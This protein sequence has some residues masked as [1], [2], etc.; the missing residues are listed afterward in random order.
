[1]RP[2][3]N[4]NVERFNRTLA[5]MLTVYCEKGQNRW[6]EFLP[7]VLMAYRSSKHSST[8][9]LPNMM[10]LGRNITSPF[11]DVIRRPPS[12]GDV[13]IADYISDLHAKLHSV[14]EIARKNLKT[15]AE[16][17]K[18]NYDLKAI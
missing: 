5:A 17:Q 6:D 12:A 16:Y 14:H 2:Q 18:R 10:V 11:E 13:D 8:H 1:M 7:K 9:F 4:G 15:S 3:S